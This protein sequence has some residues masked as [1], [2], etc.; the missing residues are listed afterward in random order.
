MLLKPRLRPLLVPE[1]LPFRKAISA[2]D[3]RPDYGLLLIVR[4]D[5]RLLGVLSNGDVYRAA[6]SGSSLDVPVGEVCN[7]TPLTLL[8]GE[9][10]R[11]AAVRERFKRLLELRGV[12]CLP[13]L[14]AQGR[15]VDILRWTDIERKG[16]GAV[17]RPRVVVVGGAGYLGTVLTQQLL[18]RNYRVRV[19]DNFTHENYALYDLPHQNDIEIIKQDMR[20]IRTVVA[21]LDDV[22]AVVLLAAVVGDP[23]GRNNPK[24][25]IE[26]NYLAAKMTAEAAKYACVP[27]FVYASTCSVYGVGKKLLD[28]RAPL[29]PVSH[30]AKTKIAAE[31][32]I[33]SIADRSFAPTILRMSTLFGLSPRMRFD[34]VANVF[35]LN[36]VRKKRIDVHGG[37]QWRPLLSVQDAAGAFVR[38]IEAPIARTAGQ[39]FN[40]G[41]E[42]QNLRIQQLAEITKGVYPRTRIVVN[43]SA[44]DV[45][46]YRISFSKIRRSLGFLPCHGVADAIREMGEFVA[47]HPAEKLDSGKY[48]NQ[49]LDY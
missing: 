27:R 28:E 25:T 12:L 49:S 43:R 30:Y 2:L 48:V 4:R 18:A 35:A 34:L 44:E 45:R 36:A 38:V 8:A 22:R 31:R 26:I 32:A 41:S 39:V 46:D 10:R 6:F 23:A 17:A 37:S 42:E 29:A 1:T 9:L 7:K 3:Q 13:V 47:K 20:D 21:A 16:A 24:A 14:D 19:L 33:L 40:V 15:P 5:G 11:P